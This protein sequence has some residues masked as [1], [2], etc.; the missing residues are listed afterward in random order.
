MKF[1]AVGRRTA[2]RFVFYLINQPQQTAAE[3]IAA[4]QELKKNVKLCELCFNPFD[5]A[6]G[7]PQNICNICS[8][9]GRA[10]H[11][12]CVVEKEADLLAIESSKRYKG[13]YFILGGTLPHALRLDPLKKRIAGNGFQEIIIAVNSTPDGK[14]TRALVERAVRESSGPSLK[15]TRLAQGLPSGSEIEYADEETL[16]SAFESRK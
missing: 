14:A 11:Q 13:L 4:I 6:Q 7:K 15:I 16:E 9:G 3:L 12:L 5:L 2:G 10:K 8:D 1:P